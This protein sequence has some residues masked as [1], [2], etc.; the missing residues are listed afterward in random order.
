MLIADQALSGSAVAALPNNLNGFDLRFAR[1]IFIVVLVV[2]NIGLGDDP[3]SLLLPLTD[4]LPYRIG[5]MY[6]QG[7]SDI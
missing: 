3:T 6:S 2:K 7:L 1:R 4:L 5:V